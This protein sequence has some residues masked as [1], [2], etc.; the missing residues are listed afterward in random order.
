M[1]VTRKVLSEGN[2]AQPRAGDVITVH[3]TGYLVNGKKKFWSTLDN[4]EPFSFRVGLGQVIQGWDEGML[5]M[6]TGEKAELTM[7][8][9]FAYGKKGFPAWGIP[10]DADLL[11]EIELLKIN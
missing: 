8:G 3:C 4:N 2:G 6:S 5:M 1:G 7:S 11:F 9:D 10:P